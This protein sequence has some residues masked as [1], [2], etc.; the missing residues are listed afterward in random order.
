MSNPARVLYLLV[1]G[2]GDV[3][4]PAFGDRTPLEVAHTPYLDALAAGGLNGLLDPVE[5]GL[6]CGSDT[7]HMSIFGYDPR[8][9][10]R[11]RGAFESMGAGIAMAPGDI[12]FKC[13][14]A[15]LDTAS[16]I[17]TS[18]RA[19]R[20]FE[21]LG[22][23]LCAALD[24]LPVPGYPGYHVTVRYATEHRCGVAV[25]GPGLSDAVGDTDPLKD[26]LP[27][28]KSG[29]TDDSPE[30]AFTAGLVNAL[31]E[32]LQGVLETHPINDQRRAAGEAVANV[33]L[34][35]GCGSRIRVPCF[36][37]KHHMRGCLVAPTKIIAGLGLS[38]DIDSLEAPG[39]TGSYNSDLSSKA[40]TICAALTGAISSP[41][42]QLQASEQA[43]ADK[44]EQ[45]RKEEASQP[46]AL[47]AEQWANP[48][49]GGGG[50]Q[51][52]FV[53]VK[54]VD[55]T[56]HDRM[57]GFKVRFLEA[58]DKMVG[59]V[60]RRLWEA[61][62][63][64]RGRYVVVVSGDHS[65]PVMF[66]DHSNEPVPF[67]ICNVRHAVEA[68]G[69]PAHVTKVPLAPIPMPDVKGTPPKAE[70]LCKQAVFKDAR[71]KASWAGRPWDP[72]MPPE[73]FGPWRDPWPTCVR[74]DP[75]RCYDEVSAARGGLGR[76]PGSQVLTLVKQFAGVTP[77]G[78]AGG[79][80]Q[81]AGP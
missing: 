50:Y 6:A 18:R 40:T 7:A 69:G 64:G 42:Q 14:F 81:G 75:V 34:L 29:P 61:E 21:H 33:V 36:H 17:V 48:G 70:D 37:D 38:F 80:G 77:L 1:D 53:H 63:A 73:L 66:G 3:S 78:A 60:L 43:Q 54:A 26:N 10:Y 68:L 2:I 15:T 8:I 74:G 76:F 56:G 11:G 25:S 49:P 13:N 47:T 27:L 12:A 51:F 32:A 62:A 45:G 22:P 35:R 5:P 4:I 24:G 39:A 20:H 65:T 23:T 9:H 67:I 28:R 16:G 58:V 31:S 55:D 59:Q 30:A 41:D 46:P 79:A 71:R 52:G 72:A 44:A 57:V 19:D